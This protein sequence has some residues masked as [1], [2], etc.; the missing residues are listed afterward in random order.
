MEGAVADGTFYVVVCVVGVVFRRG[1]GGA[2]TSCHESVA[3]RDCA[4]EPYCPRDSF[5]A[6]DRAPTAVR[7]MCAR[8]W[9]WCFPFSGR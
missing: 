3:G 9:R 7:G 4:E 2:G 1:F 8:P 5:V 6:F